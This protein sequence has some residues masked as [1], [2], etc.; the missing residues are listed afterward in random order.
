[1]TLLGRFTILSS[2]QLVFDKLS[3]MA[4]LNIGNLCI[5]VQAGLVITL[6]ALVIERNSSLCF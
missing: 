6:F 2:S 4:P 3:D 5:E 1:M